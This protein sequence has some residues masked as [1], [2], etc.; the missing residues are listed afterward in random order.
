MVHAQP[1]AIAE[2]VD[3]LTGPELRIDTARSEAEASNKIATGSYSIL[4]AAHMPPLLDGAHLLEEAVRHQPD[5]FRI[6]LA[7]YASD[8]VAINSAQVV[9]GAID[10][11]IPEAATLAVA[12]AQP[13]G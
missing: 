10:R 12:D 6:L 7:S 5:A 9:Y 2:L 11:A 3:L 13:V 1:E 8:A 4:I